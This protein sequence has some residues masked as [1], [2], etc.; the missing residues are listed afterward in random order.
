M[1]VE[2]GQSPGGYKGM[3]MQLCVH[4]LV[5]YWEWWWDGHT[6]NQYSRWGY[7]GKQPSMNRDAPS[8]TATWYLSAASWD[9]WCSNNPNV[10]LTTHQSTPG[11]MWQTLLPHLETPL[12]LPVDMTRSKFRRTRHTQSIPIRVALLPTGSHGPL[13]GHSDHL[14]WRHCRCPV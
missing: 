8:E 3:P 2:T 4:T 7:A 6:Q 1:S 5:K 14:Q 11:S 12:C 13:L 10:S 9:L